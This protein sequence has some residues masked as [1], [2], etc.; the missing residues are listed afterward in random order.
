[1]QGTYRQVLSWK[2]LLVY[3]AAQKRDTGGLRWLLQGPSSERLR[4]STPLNGVDHATLLMA[5]AIIDLAMQSVCRC[6]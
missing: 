5:A 4:G 1:M 3:E 2:V 6:S